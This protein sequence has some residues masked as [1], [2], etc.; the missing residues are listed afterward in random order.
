MQMVPCSTPTLHTSIA[1]V[2]ITMH[3]TILPLGVQL[4]CSRQCGSAAIYI[5]IYL[6]EQCHEYHHLA[7]GMYTMIFKSFVVHTGTC[8]EYALAIGLYKASYMQCVVQS[9]III[10]QL[11][12]SA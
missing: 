11:V 12:A 1:N 7:S 2:N 3:D 10:L 4:E 8:C 5:Y 6:S 9:Q